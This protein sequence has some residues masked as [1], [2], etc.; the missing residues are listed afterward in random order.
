MKAFSKVL[1]AIA[2]IIIGGLLLYQSN[3]VGGDVYDTTVSC[4]DTDGGIDYYVT[5]IVTDV[6]TFCPSAQPSIG[7]ISQDQISKMSSF[8]G[9]ERPTISFINRINTRQNPQT[10]TYTYSDT[11]NGVILT[12]Y[13][14][15]GDNKV[16]TEYPC[17]NGCSNGACLQTPLNHHVYA[18]IAIDTE[19]RALQNNI[20]NQELD[21]SQYEPVS[22]GAVYQ[23]MQTT[24]R[25]TLLDSNGTP[26]KLTWYLMTAEPYCQSNNS[27]CLAVY[28]AMLPEWEDEAAMWGDEMQLHYHNYIWSDRDNDSVFYWNQRLVFDQPEFEKML[29]MLLVERKFFPSSYRGGWVWEDND[30]SNYLE[31]VMPNDFSSLSPLVRVDDGEDAVGNIYDWSQALQKWYYYHPST[32]NYQLPGDQERTMFR[33]KS[34]ASSVD[35][36]FAQTVTENQPAFV[37]TYMHNYGPINNNLNAFHAALEEKSLETDIDFTYVTATEAHKLALGIIDDTSPELTLTIETGEIGKELHIVSSEELF[38]DPY[39]AAKTP[40]GEYIRMEVQNA[41]SNAWNVVIPVSWEGQPYTIA[42]GAS[43]YAGNTAAASYTS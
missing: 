2:V 37:C 43:D 3:I 24:A 5:G 11:C 8:E 33:C 16:S 13:Y 15:D 23:A 14:C 41:G 29:N 28:D 40:D 25:N 31:T 30:M 42:V 19:T 9:F 1:V 22:T 20:Y 27:D 6:T 7:P 34:G 32:D 12:E 36:G 4:S 26:M 18:V 10:C 17:D 35:E 38:K 21:L 39:V